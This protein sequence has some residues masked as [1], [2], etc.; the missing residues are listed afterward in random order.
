MGPACPLQEP[1]LLDDSSSSNPIAE[2][3]LAVARCAEGGTIARNKDAPPNGKPAGRCTGVRSGSRWSPRG[4]P[5]PLLVVPTSARSEEMVEPRNCVPISSKVQ[6][7]PMDRAR[8]DGQ[9]RA[10]KLDWE[11]GRSEQG[12]H[13]MRLR[14]EALRV[15]AALTARTADGVSRLTRERHSGVHADA[16]SWEKVHPHLRPLQTGGTRSGRCGEASG[17]GMRRRAGPSEGVSERP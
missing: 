11:G 17:G 3:R 8:L 1:D 5:G 7:H 13:G 14:E 2:S 10:P 4:S 16:R 9:Q 15:G 6:S 12:V